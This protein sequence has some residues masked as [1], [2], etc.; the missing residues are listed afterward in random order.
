M[1]ELR[2]LVKPELAKNVKFKP[3]LIL[4]RNVHV[5]RHLLLTT[6][7]TWHWSGKHKG[8]LMPTLD[9]NRKKVNLWDEHKFTFNGSGSAYVWW[10]TVLYSIYNSSLCLSTGQRSAQVLLVNTLN[11]RQIWALSPDTWI[12]WGKDITSIPLYFK[13][14]MYICRNI[15]REIYKYE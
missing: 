15:N 12:P 6:W 13:K 2:W 7:H 4:Q 10:E 11:E 3:M 14:Y 9:S 1:E 8:S 5:L